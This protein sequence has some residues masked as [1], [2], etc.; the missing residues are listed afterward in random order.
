MDGL[1][2]S[3]YQIQTEPNRGIADYKKIMR[4]DGDSIFFRTIGEPK[5]GFEAWNIKSKFK[6]TSGGIETEDENFD[7]IY[8]HEISNDSV[9][10]S[11]K[12]K[13]STQ[14]VF[15]KLNQPSSRI[16]WNPSSN[17]YEFEGNSEKVNI[18]FLENGLYADYLPEIEDVTVGHWHTIQESNNLFVV[19]DGLNI[20][21]LSVDSLINDK[22]YLSIHDEAKFSYTFKQQ[23]LETPKNLLGNWELVTCD[24]LRTEHSLLA[25]GNKW[26]TLDFLRIERD[27]IFITNNNSKYAK[28]WTIGGAN[29]LIIFPDAIIKSDS[30]ER[31]TLSKREHI[32]RRNIFKIDSL[33]EN[34]L[35]ILT[36][37][38]LA[39]FDGFEIKL[40]YR[41]KKN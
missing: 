19:L 38:E 35:I 2:V 10:I 29:N 31:D 21:A 28:K 5:N 34:D 11:Y 24:T 37:Y 8:I 7:K 4:I 25:Q 36:E 39:E 26:S 1:W 15:Q 14:E 23:S 9:V 20:I 3:A 12:T 6:R 18:T 16:N 13:N 33:S 17:S 32:V 41:R 27:S 30:L 22:T 40:T